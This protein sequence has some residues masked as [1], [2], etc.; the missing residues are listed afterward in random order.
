[1]NLEIP[2]VTGALYPP[3]QIALALA[4]ADASDDLALALGNRQSPP[5]TLQSI[6]CEEIRRPVHTQLDIARHR[7]RLRECDQPRIVRRLRI[8]HRDRGPVP[9]A[10]GP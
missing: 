9:R 8:E 4:G 2:D 3:V 7:A 1:M 6:E 5:R 10:R